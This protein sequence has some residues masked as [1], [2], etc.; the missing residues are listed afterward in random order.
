MKFCVTLL[1][2]GSGTRVGG[3]PL[4]KYVRIYSA[5]DLPDLIEKLNE[6]AVFGRDILELNI[7]TV[8]EDLSDE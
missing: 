1:V 5:K 4:G 8:S 3:L 7:Q 2:D 6:N